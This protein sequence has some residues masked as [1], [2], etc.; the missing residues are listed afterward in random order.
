MT[1]TEIESK[2]GKLSIKR[3]LAYYPIRYHFVAFI[4]GCFFLSNFMIFQST[5]EQIIKEMLNFFGFSST[6]INGTFLVGD[7]MN[8]AKI[9][10][11]VYPQLL[12]ITVFSTF[13]L[14]IGRFKLIN[15]IKFILYAF[16]YFITSAILQFFII[17]FLLLLDIP[18]SELASTFKIFALFFVTI[19]G[20][21]FMEYALFTHITFPTPTKIKPVIK[22]NYLKEYF[23]FILTIIT[24]IPILYSYITFIGLDFKTPIPLLV[25]LHLWWN[26]YTI[27][28]FAIYVANLI[29]EIRLPSWLK[30]SKSSQSN[31]N[32]PSVTYLIPV[33]NEEM[34]IG[35]L[36]ESIDKAA[37]KYSGKVD[38][39]LVN[40]GS[41]DNT[42]KVVSDAFSNLKYCTGQLISIPN[43]GKGF[44]LKTGLQR[45]TGD[46]IFR[47]DGDSRMDENILSP[48]MHHFKDPQ[49][50]SVG[51]WTYGIAEKSLMQKIQCMMCASYFY[52]KRGQ[53]IVDGIITQPGPS[54]CFRKEAIQI[55]G[56]WIDN[57]FGEDGEITSRIA[58]L[59]YRNVF[60]GRSIVYS[61]IP[62]TLQGFIN[63]RARWGV[64]Y[65]HSRGRN[66]RHLRDNIMP[67]SFIF[68]WNLIGHALGLG[69]S[70]T[71][72]FLFASI[73]IGNIDLSLLEI[74]TLIL[75]KMIAIHLLI[76]SL[77]IILFAHRLNKVKRKK[78]VIFYPFLR[79]VN[80]IL[81]VYAK[82]MLVE[83][84]LS[85]SHDW[86]EYNVEAFLALRKE[87]SKK[88]DPLYPEGEAT[89]EI[90]RGR[91]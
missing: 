42:A 29:Y 43:S 6:L 56:G 12:F 35:G 89:K 81:N 52:T 36:I 66:L 58:R 72:A 24:A 23:Y 84:L 22:R 18:T 21:L 70:V 74:P 65:Y 27:L 73:T 71:W 77:W 26:I 34:Y 39:V 11:S 37:S 54:T 2:K 67:R 44:A 20:A 46:I 69:K 64:A 75:A 86:K 45:V 38:I 31:Y 30:F 33:Y 68:L 85:W 82:P 80:L 91:E 62:E 61:E 78:Y 60:E 87:V 63:Q 1:I 48:M 4:L 55:S 88:I 76:N 3:I 17:A 57:I 15:R 59:G 53:E 19:L 10:L 47:T 9:F 83:I 5:E 79:W 50:G 32:P 7:M 41:T 28:F 51:G 13:A 40:D 90:Y 49:V 8:P 16:L 25:Q 14:T